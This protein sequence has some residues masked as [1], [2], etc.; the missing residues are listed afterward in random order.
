[1][2]AIVAASVSALLRRLGDD[3][4]ANLVEYTLLVAFIAMAC[5]VA[6]SAI[7]G[8]TTEPFSEVGSGFG[9]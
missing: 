2:N 1:M 6:V 3:R 5:V 4:G 7:G 9:N 8:S